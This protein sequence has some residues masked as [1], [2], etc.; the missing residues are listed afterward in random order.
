MPG[1]QGSLAR[2]T[3]RLGKA[4]DE[5]PWRAAAPR[6]APV[7]ESDDKFEPADLR[8]LLVRQVRPR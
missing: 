8:R 6:E 3:G 1:A 2:F 5:Q 4:L 7:W